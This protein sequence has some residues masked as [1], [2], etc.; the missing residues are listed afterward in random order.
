MCLETP[1]KISTSKD[2]HKSA[3]TLAAFCA[4]ALGTGAKQKSLRGRNSPMCTLSQNGYGGKLVVPLGQTFPI[5]L[6]LAPFK[7]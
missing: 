1:A 3:K 7:A 6:G 5:G 4:K 2:P